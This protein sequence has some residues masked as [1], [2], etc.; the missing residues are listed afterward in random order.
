MLGA[1]SYPIIFP[2][3]EWIINLGLAS[4]QRQIVKRFT[5]SKWIT[6]FMFLALCVGLVSV[7]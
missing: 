6:M 4:L 5:I 7:Y 1:F 2:E 3:S